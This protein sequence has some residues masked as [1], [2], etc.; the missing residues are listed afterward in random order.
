MASLL[1][2]P[3]TDCFEETLAASQFFLSSEAFQRQ[4]DALVQDS[5]TG[6]YRKANAAEVFDYF[7][8]GEYD[9]TL[10]RFECD[11]P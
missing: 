8:G 6:L 4:G 3:G 5:Q 9:E 2:L 10:E 1:I 11:E 7:Y